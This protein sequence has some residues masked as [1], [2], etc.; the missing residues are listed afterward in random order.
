M[1]ATVGI[2]PRIQARRTAV[3]RGEGRRR[4]RRLQLVVIVIGAFGLSFLITLSP[5]MDVDHVRVDATGID[6]AAVREASGL[7]PGQAMTQIDPAAVADAIAELPAVESARVRRSWPASVVVEVTV[8]K[9]ATALPSAAGGWLVADGSGRIIDTAETMP[10]GVVEIRGQ[11]YDAE[12]GQWVPDSVRPITAVGAALPAELRERAAAVGP[13][14]A[15]EVDVLLADGGTVVFD[16]DG[17]H[18]TAAAAAA[19]VA[20]T[21]APGCIDSVDVTSASAPV[22]RRASAC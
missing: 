10:G 12:P 18:Q 13:G 9:P 2:D 14:D 15:G 11:A 3:L 4:L 6:A 16:A 20:R 19:A 1:T 7:R 22:L 17:N 5:F 8:R 21:V